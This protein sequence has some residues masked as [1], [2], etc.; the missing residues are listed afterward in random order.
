M[1]K[2][3]KRKK[4]VGLSLPLDWDGGGGTGVS[5]GAVFLGDNWLCEREMVAAAGRGEGVAVASGVDVFVGIGVGVGV[6]LGGR[7]VMVGVEVATAVAVGA[8]WSGAESGVAV[9]EGVVGRTLKLCLRICSLPARWTR[10][11]YVVSCNGHTRRA[12]AKETAC[13]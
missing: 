11:V 12:E 4:V 9:G 7:G 2:A 8:G 5:R 6:W 1:A 3:P 13:S 10:K